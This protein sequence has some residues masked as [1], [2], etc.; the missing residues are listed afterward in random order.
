MVWCG[1]W[2]TYV[3]GPFFFEDHVNDVTYLDMLKDKLMLQLESFGEGA[4]ELFQ[5][6]GAP[7]HF[8]TNVRDWLNNNFLN[9]IGRCNDVE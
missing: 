8:A 7:A 2:K 5:Q 6:N 4:P 9:W 1:L 3:L